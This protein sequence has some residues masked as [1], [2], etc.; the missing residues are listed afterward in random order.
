MKTSMYEDV[1]REM[2]P[3]LKRAVLRVMS[4]HQGPE[5]AIGRVELAAAVNLHGFGRGL[6]AAT[7]DRNLRS[8][9]QQLRKEGNLI[10]SSSGEGGY[11]LARD[12]AEYEEFATG[13]YR[14]K[15]VDMSETLRAM[16]TAAEKRFGKTAPAGQMRLL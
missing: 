15:I 2:E 4:M 7:F 9:I 3:G 14:A 1:I 10:C 8:A 13:E 5:N 16:D 12:M 6:G 11:Y